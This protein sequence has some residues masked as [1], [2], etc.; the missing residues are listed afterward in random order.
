[1]SN[2]RTVYATKHE[3]L[4][5]TL[6]TRGTLAT[7]EGQDTSYGDE[8]APTREYNQIERPISISDV[9]IKTRNAGMSSQKAHIMAKA[10][11]E[12]ANSLEYDV[13]L[14]TRTAFVEDSTAAKMGGIEEFISDNVTAA[15][16]NPLDEKMFNDLASDVFDDGGTPTEVFCR[17]NLKRQ[18]SSWSVNIRRVEAADKRL[19]RPVD[20]YVGEFG[21][22][23]VMISRD[24]TSGSLLLLDPKLWALAYM[25]NPHT[26]ARAKTGSAEKSVIIG[27]VTLE[28]LQEK[29]NG[30]LTGISTV[31]G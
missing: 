18:V 22:V 3:W 1:M 24:V 25:I 9:M 30:E 2:K 14:S 13:I 19:I 8:V 28:S 21:T 6:A 31:V 10:A 16:D 27:N 5:D 20:I 17:G 11:A 26:E 29:G 15:G 7:I 23:K 12:F 4:V